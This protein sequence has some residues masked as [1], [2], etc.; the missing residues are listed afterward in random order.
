MWLLS[1]PALHSIEVAFNT[2]LRKIWRLPR[3]SHTGIVHSVAN[4]YSL[5]N[6]VCLRSQH[7][8]LSAMSCSSLLAID[9]SFLI[10]ALFAALSQA[11]IQ[12]VV[13]VTSRGM[14]YK[15]KFVPD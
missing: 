7:L 13:I 10:P 11:I 9:K 6:V 15:I 1:S 12:C 4:L 3:H 2:I 8:M 5:Y 14:M